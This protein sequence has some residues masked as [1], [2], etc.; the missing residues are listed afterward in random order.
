MSSRS[1]FFL[2]ELGSSHSDLMQLS[3]S[4]SCGGYLSNRN[5]L[6]ALHIYFAPQQLQ[7]AIGLYSSKLQKV[8]YT[9]S[10]NNL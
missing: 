1:L 10:Y 9:S 3:R 7:G 5:Y 4:V 6:S 2:Q 8:R